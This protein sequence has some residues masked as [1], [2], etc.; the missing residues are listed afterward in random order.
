MLKVTG[1][2][3]GHRGRCIHV[4]WRASEIARRSSGPK[5]KRRQKFRE[6]GLVFGTTILLFVYL[7]QCWGLNPGPC[8]C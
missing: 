8:T 2:R 5:S 7:L 4:A 3:H 6:L 1:R